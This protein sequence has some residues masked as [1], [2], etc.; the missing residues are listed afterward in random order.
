LNLE[1]GL[2]INFGEALFKNGI[3]RVVNNYQPSASQRLCVRNAF[4]EAD[5]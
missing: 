2:L 3:K 4:I 1:V 5:N